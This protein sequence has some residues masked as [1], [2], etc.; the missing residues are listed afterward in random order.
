MKALAPRT[1]AATEHRFVIGR[2]STED[3][4][5]VTPRILAL[6]YVCYCNVGSLIT[7]ELY[8]LNPFTCVGAD[9]ASISKF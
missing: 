1:I 9:G 5:I 3:I 7:V 4:L 8:F 6:L 2:Y